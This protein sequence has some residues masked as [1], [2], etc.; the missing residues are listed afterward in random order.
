[1]CK[2]KMANE[3]KFRASTTTLAELKVYTTLQGID[4]WCVNPESKET[5]EYTTE[6]FYAP[7]NQ[8]KSLDI[9]H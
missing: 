4:R 3:Y 1:M 2:C 6:R 9:S 7:T 5:M 8:D